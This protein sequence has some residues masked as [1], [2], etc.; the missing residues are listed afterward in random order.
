MSTIGSARRSNASARSE[1]I[2]NSSFRRRTAT[3]IAM[4]P[5]SVRISY[6]GMAS[7]LAPYGNNDVL[8]LARE[9]DAK[10]EKILIAVAE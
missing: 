5:G 7:Y 4:K 3:P 1:Q 9:L 6:D 8:N 10:L 2:K